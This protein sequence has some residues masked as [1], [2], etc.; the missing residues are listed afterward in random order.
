VVKQEIVMSSADAIKW[1]ERY[2][3]GEAAFESPR[4]FLPRRRSIADRGLAL[5][6]D[7]SA[8][9]PDFSSSAACG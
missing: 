1:N 5:D 6:I 8:A 3:S 2:R 9:T 4:D 7:G